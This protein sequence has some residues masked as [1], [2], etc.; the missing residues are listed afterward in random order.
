MLE[1]AGLQEVDVGA[2]FSELL[3]SKG[4]QEVTKAKKAAYLA[5]S[6][7]KNFAVPELESARPVT[8]WP[9]GLPASCCALSMH[10]LM[11]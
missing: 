11:S 2:A 8:F 10:G 5:A 6:A 4:A 1:E 9:L 3:A 7:M